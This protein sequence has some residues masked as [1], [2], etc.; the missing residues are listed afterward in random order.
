[1][2]DYDFSYSRIAKLLKVS[3][4]TIQ[5]RVNELHLARLKHSEISDGELGLLMSEIMHQFPNIG[6]RSME[7]HLKAIGHN[8]QWERV[9][10]FMW[11][12]DPEAFLLRSLHSNIIHRKTYNVPSPRCL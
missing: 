5:R 11:M 12:V 1:M 9:R 2:L 7:G 10:R 8:V 6:V 4:K 3:K